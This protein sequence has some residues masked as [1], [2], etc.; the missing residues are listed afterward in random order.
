MYL[1]SIDRQKAWVFVIAVAAFATVP[2][3]L[4]FVPFAQNK[5]GNGAMGGAIAS[6]ITEVGMVLAAM[7]LIPAGIIGKQTLWYTLKCVLA[8][9]G[10]VLCVY[11]LG[12]EIL[13]LQIIIGVIS[14]TIFTFILRLI[15]P[16]DMEMI[17]GGIQGYLS[18]FRREATHP[19]N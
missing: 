6:M 3:D 16:D 8:G 15:S 1:M 14:F 18:K 13:P 5:F 17:K 11:F 7:F 2:L 9:A 12:M 19:A 4:I 10:M